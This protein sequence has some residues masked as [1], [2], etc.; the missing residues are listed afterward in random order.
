[1][2]DAH[3]GENRTCDFHKWNFF[4][5]QIEP[6]LYF[7]PFDCAKIYLH[8]FCR[9]GSTRAVVLR[10]M[11]R[12]FQAIKKRKSRPGS[13]KLDDFSPVDIFLTR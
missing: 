3:R 7:S 11:I 4:A 9:S 13:E 10:S 6:A 1:M 12:A 2:S 5:A 8:T